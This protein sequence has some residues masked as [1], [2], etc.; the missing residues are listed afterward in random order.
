MVFFS[1]ACEAERLADFYI[2]VGQI[3]NETAFDATTY[4]ICAYQPGVIG[5]SKTRIFQCEQPIK[6]RFVTV[7]FPMTRTEILTLCE[8]AVYEDYDGMFFKS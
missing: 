2:R 6:G 5:A 1:I 3:F 7:H 4:T 8:V